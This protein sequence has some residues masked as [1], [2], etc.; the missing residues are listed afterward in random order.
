MI[1]LINRNDN[2]EIGVASNYSNMRF[3][4]TGF[5]VKEFEKINKDGRKNN[6]N[7]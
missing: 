4:S 2:D 1:N 5:V 3:W 6:Q 7:S